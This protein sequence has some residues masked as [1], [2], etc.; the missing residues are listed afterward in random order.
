MKVLPKDLLKYLESDKNRAKFWLENYKKLINQDKYTWKEKFEKNALQDNLTEQEKRTLEMLGVE[1]RTSEE[2][3][4]SERTY[5]FNI[6]VLKRKFP[7][8][9]KR[10][11]SAK[12]VYIPL[13]YDLFK[14]AKRA[15]VFIY[16]NGIKY[17]KLLQ[18][19]CIV[20]ETEY[21]ENPIVAE[22]DTKE[23]PILKL[24][25]RKEEGP[26]DLRVEIGQC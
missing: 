3:Y 1:T 14:S 16:H 12:D 4:Q 25:L 5:Q 23:P 15:F 21:P 22:L 24:Y 19:W 10:L 9:E 7:V 6:P 20:I 26:I 2:N 13:D 8:Y 11:S 17:L 18:G